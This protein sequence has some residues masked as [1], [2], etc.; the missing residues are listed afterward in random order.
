MSSKIEKLENKLGELSREINEKK[1]P[2]MILFEG[3]V[4]SG[5]SRLSNELYMKLDAKYTEFIATKMPS[6]DDL[7]YP[8][9]YSY[10]KT[11]PKRGSFNLYFRSWYAQ[12]IQYKENRLKKSV[13]E[14]YDVLIEQI[15]HFEEMLIE[16]DYEIIKFYLNID[17]D[18]R[19]EHIEKTK[20]NPLTK[21]KAEEYEQAIDES[22]YKKTMD[23][24]MKKT[25][26]KLSPWH[27]I[28]YTEREETVEE[29]YE[30]IIE[31]LED[32]LKRKSK[33]DE[34]R[35]VDGD[36]TKDYK[37]EILTNNKEKIDK[38]D[39]NEILPKLQHR[40]R[41]LQYA[42]Y[43]RKIPLVLVYEGIDAAG[44]GGN[45]KRIRKELDPTGYKINAISAPTDVELDH[46]Y[47]WRFA[48]DM[49]RSG[50]IE[51]FDR[52]WYGRVL[53]ERVEGFASVNEWKRAYDEIN[54]Y[55]KMLSDD[56]A[57]IM[58]F[59]ITIDKDEQQER[60]ED[61]QEDEHK[62]WKITE[63]DW[64]NRENW[65]LYIEASEDMINKTSTD[66]APWHVVPG[67]QKKYA[68]I[69]ALKEIIKA[70][71]KRLFGVERY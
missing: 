27:K 10:W 13:Y 63:E 52:S 64:R 5:K 29:M 66:Y 57:I 19:K 7:R 8:F 26:S 59:F 47:L 42:L 31:A 55:E 32:A 3:P 16:D 36:F 62:Q 4:A 25:D 35:E 28:D 1:I 33:K 39:Y 34:K 24:L 58:K 51:F 22:V 53:V 49:P 9:L 11:L 18:K 20:K 6:E 23:K 70:C 54:Q 40:M 14:D 44:K 50:H 56:G 69:Y 15:K 71:E 45:I 41:E 17:D 43:E 21:W 60:F 30:I 46:H 37:A 48:T 61:R 38:A 68:R 2:V 65:D 67:N 12:F